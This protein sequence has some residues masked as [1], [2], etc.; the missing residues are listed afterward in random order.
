MM[1]GRWRSLSLGLGFLVLLARAASADLYAPPAGGF[2]YSFDAHPGEDVPGTSAAGAFDALDGSFGHDNGS[3][4]WNG[5][6]IVGDAAKPG[7]VMAIE[8][9]YLRLQDT[10]DPRQIA[11][12]T[13]PSN[14][15][16]YLGHK[17]DTAPDA[18]LDSGVTLHFRARVPT[19]GTLDQLVGA[20]GVRSPYPASGDGYQIHDG[21][22][23]AI[24]IKQRSGGIVSFGF[25]T[26]F[27]AVAA[28]AG[29]NTNNRNGTAI[30]ADVDTADAGQVNLLSLDPTQWHEFWI[31]IQS[32]GAGTHQVRVW[33]DGRA[34][35]VATFDVT[36]G[37][38]SDFADV[39]YLAFG[40]GSTGQS[41]ALDI[42]FVRVAVGAHEAKLPTVE[43]APAAS[44]WALALTTLALVAAGCLLLG[45]RRPAAM[46]A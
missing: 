5:A 26:A 21:G 17:L 43:S 24:G 30:S 11:G 3:D 22:K 1:L 15:K 19:D 46:A 18:L 42:D 14:R 45:R 25:L 20:G 40:L 35:P 12:T 39:S 23:G 37:S 44:T 36:A 10:G 4:S 6:K 13:D 32:G 16:L 9:G 34:S 28:G 8:P 31:T 38:G 2:L 29:F 7:G 33:M 27:D 41:G